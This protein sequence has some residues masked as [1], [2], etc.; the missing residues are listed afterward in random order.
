MNLFTILIVFF[1]GAA[2]G[3]FLG[4]LVDRLPRGESVLFGR[5]KC[6]KCKSELTFLDLIPVVSYILLSGKCRTC[7]VKIPVHLFLFEMLSGFSAVA[8]LLYSQTLGLS[9]IETVFLAVVLFCLAGIFFAD[10][11]SGIIPD[12]F[13]A[14]LII[15][16]LFFIGFTDSSALPWYI[17]TAIFSS[18]LFLALYLVTK[19]RGMGFGDVKFAFA[20]GL[21]LGFPLILVGL[22]TAFLTATAISLILVL[23]GRKKLH[24]GTIA[25]G[26]FLVA[27][28]IAAY[29]FGRQILNLFF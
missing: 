29:L 10:T 14:V 24:G 2:L 11:L 27:G 3:S 8:L 6:E 7:H 13:V 17:I 28:T 19:G 16:V 12:Q 5:S 18:G 20:M 21:I 15:T 4:V 1:T 23:A 26:P 22:Y 9:I 25:F